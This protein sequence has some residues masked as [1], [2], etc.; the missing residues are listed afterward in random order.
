M[1]RFVIRLSYYTMSYLQHSLQFSTGGFLVLVEGV[2]VDVQ[3]GGG[4]GV[5]KDARHCGHVCAARDHQT[6][7]GVAQAVDVEVLRQAVLFQDALE[8]PG[9]GSGRH[10]Q[11]CALSAEQ[12]IVGGQFSFVIGLSNVLA[13]VPVLPQKAFHFSGEVDVPVAGAGLG[14]LDEDLVAG[15]FHGVAADVDGVLFPVD[16][17]P[18]QSAALTPPHPRGDDELEVRLVLDALVLKRGDDLLRR[19]LVGNLFL[20]FLACIAV[21]ALCGVRASRFAENFLK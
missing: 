1:A 17:P 10:R 2:S 20:C 19:F 16:V 15:D 4:L 21:G 3:R 6:G 7:G 14:F 5:T 11:A 9:E 18:L 13:L 12:E 8:P